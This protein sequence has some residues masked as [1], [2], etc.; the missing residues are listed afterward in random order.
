[1]PVILSLTEH[2]DEIWA[3]GPEGLFLYQDGGAQDF[4]SPLAVPQPDHHPSCCYHDGERLLV[5]GATHGV[6]YTTED[7]GWRASWVDG[8]AAP[9]VCL[10]PHPNYEHIGVLLAGSSGGGI[11][12]STNRGRDF[13][14]CNFGLMDFDVLTLAWA[15]LQPAG[16]WPP[17][18]VVFAGASNGVYRSPNA[19]RGWKQIAVLPAPVLSLAVAPTFH[20]GGPVLVGT[21]GAGLWR[22]DD[23]GYTFCP[24]PDA[25]EVINAMLALPDG[26]LLSDAERIWRS[27]DGN[28]WTPL[29]LPPA[30][31]FLRTRQGIVLAGGVEGVFQVE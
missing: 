14:V 24:V 16:D 29:N 3:L 19:G 22:S 28:R 18:E 13:F 31:T 15:P 12:R 1:M 20:H 21:E 8:V 26:W 4:S 11:L 30:L 10:A 6:A 2:H 7:G 9:V 25:P 5:G 23:G 27:Q 17:L